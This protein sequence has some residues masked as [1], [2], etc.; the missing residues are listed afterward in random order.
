MSSQQRTVAPIMVH[1][2]AELAQEEIPEPGH[3]MIDVSEVPMTAVDSTFYPC[4]APVIVQDHGVELPESTA[5]GNVMSTCWDGSDT[6]SC[7]ELNQ[8]PRRLRLVWNPTQPGPDSHEER[9]RRV[10]QAMQQETR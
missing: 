6:E 2:F 10:R 8:P 3:T 5:P 1:R 9:F 4:V 7:G